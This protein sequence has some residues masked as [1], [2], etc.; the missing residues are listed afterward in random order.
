MDHH[1]GCQVREKGSAFFVITL[2]AISSTVLVGAFLSTSLA[3]VRH[4][5]YR[6]A[7][8]SAFNAAESGLAK[9]GYHLELVRRMERLDTVPALPDALPIPA[10]TRPAED[11]RR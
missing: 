5:E 3:K 1:A 8:S 9:A 10:I 2:F 7:E 11:A 6:V 4:V